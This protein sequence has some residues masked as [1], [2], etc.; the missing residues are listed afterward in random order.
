[1]VFVWVYQDVLKQ[2]FT[3][4]T[5]LSQKSTSAVESK[6]GK[7]LELER[8]AGPFTEIPLNN[9]VCSPLGLIPKKTPGEF[10]LIH[11]LSYPEGKSINCLILPEN[12]KVQYESIENVIHLIK[13]FGPHALMAK[14]GYRGWFQ[15]H[16]LTLRRLSFA[17][18]SVAR[19]IL[20]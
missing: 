3:K 20:L 18:L 6:L 13:T 7:E 1:M 4:I 14:K 15:K 19:Q 10:R 17:R 8:I 12:S 5:S 9:F 2:Q 16:P 11:D